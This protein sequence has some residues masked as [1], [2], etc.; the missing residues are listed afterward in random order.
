MAWIEKVLDKLWRE[1]GQLHPI[2]SSRRTHFVNGSDNCIVDPAVL[3]WRERPLE[4]RLIEHAPPR[5]FVVVTG[6]VVL[7]QFIRKS[8]LRIPAGNAR[9]VVGH[10]LASRVDQ[11]GST[12]VSGKSTFG[13]IGL[14]RIAPEKGEEKNASSTIPAAVWSA[15]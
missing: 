8:A 4:I 11:L 10:L 14:I 15:R 6:V 2:K 7:A 3:R 13:P 9:E 12:W 5:Q 1:T